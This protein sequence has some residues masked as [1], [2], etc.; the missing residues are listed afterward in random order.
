M[1]ARSITPLILGRVT[2]RHRPISSCF[3]L[4]LEIK[5]A[6]NERR[7][8]FVGDPEFSWALFFEFLANRILHTV[9]RPQKHAMTWALT[10]SLSLSEKKPIEK[11]K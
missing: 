5:R 10:E 7:K 2:H 4:S 9:S 3:F 1:R 11:G 6:D 8:L